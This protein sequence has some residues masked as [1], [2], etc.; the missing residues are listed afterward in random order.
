MIHK[1][2]EVVG[3][4]V[5]LEVFVDGLLKQKKGIFWESEQFKTTAEG[6]LRPAL[7][8]IQPLYESNQLMELLAMGRE[9]RKRINPKNPILSIHYGVDQL[10]LKYGGKEKGFHRFV[11]ELDYMLGVF[12]NDGN[13]EVYD[14]YREP[15]KKAGFRIK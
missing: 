3:E 14:K 5:L 9:P 10:L 6:N 11:G 13:F 4:R 12:L 1:A 2:F 7:D 8:F 15:L